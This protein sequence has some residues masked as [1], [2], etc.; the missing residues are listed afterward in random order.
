M[1][2]GRQQRNFAPKEDY[3]FDDSFFEDE[4]ELEE[5]E[6]SESPDSQDTIRPDI[7]DRVFRSLSAD[8][9][10]GDNQLQRGDINRAYLRKNLSIAECAVI[11][12]RI[13]DNGY[14][15]LDDDESDASASSTTA[16]GRAHRYLTES[17][18]RDFGRQIQLALRLPADTSRLDKAYVD[19][20]L[21]DAERARAAFV[22]SNTRFVEQ[23]ARRLGEH[24]HLLLE[25]AIQEGVLGLLHA[26][27]LYNPE[28]GFRFKTYAAWWIEQYI[29]RAIA[30]L[31]RT[32]RLPVHVQLRMASI[33][34]ARRRFTISRGR[35][36]SLS[37]LAI[38][39]GMEEEKLLKLLWYVE[40]TDCS[41]GDVSIGED[42]TLLSLVPD[43]AE[44]VIDRIIRREL[45]ALIRCAL[46]DLTPKQEH[47]IKMRFGIDMDDDHTLESVG[48]HFDLTRERIR[49]IESKALTRLRHPNRSSK[50]MD[51]L[52]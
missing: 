26:A 10:R 8:A 38:A 29:Q 32:I 28:R 47:I 48:A 19:R 9:Q 25:D 42:A 7:I 12:E 22:L 11:E 3:E 17:E 21:K 4:A 6:K 49:Q 16:A 13:I 44:P 14:E 2:K 27:N 30:N 36:P 46:S 41:E 34:K 24:R 1:E 18:E 31:D 45:Q 23:I 52:D 20:V 15:I 50:L 5:P 51:F 37:E 40:I 39:I 35:S 33:R 43:S